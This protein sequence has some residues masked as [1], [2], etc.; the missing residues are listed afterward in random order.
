M[1]RLISLL[2][3]IAIITASCL[4]MTA[5]TEDPS[6]DDDTAESPAPDCGD[7]EIVTPSLK[8]YSDKR[9]VKLSQIVYQRPDI[10]A[11]IEAF[12]AISELIRSGEGDFEQIIAAVEELEDDYESILTMRSYTQ[13]MRSADIKSEYWQGEYAVI[14]ES[15]PEFASAIED[16][17]VAAAQSPDA[18]RYEDEYFGEG[19]IEKYAGGGTLTDTLV[20]L[21]ERE[22]ELENRSSSL[23]GAN[24]VISYKSMTDTYDNVIAFYE[25]HYGKDSASCKS[26]VA[27]CTALYERECSRINRECFVELVKVRRDIADE[28]GFNTYVPVAYDDMSHD[29]TEEQML[30]YLNDISESVI[31]V[32][33]VLSTYIFNTYFDKH[34]APSLDR[35]SLIN[36]LYYVLSDMDEELADIYSYMLAFEL[37][38]VEMS[39]DERSGGSFTTYL[40]GYDAPLL[41]VST[42]GRV[43]DYFTLSHEFGH[44]A[45]YF[46]NGSS[47]ASVDI[48]EVSSTSLELLS[49][50]AL[51]GKL[52][53]AEYKYLQYAEICSA[54]ETFVYQGFYALFEHYVYA[55]G[56]DDISERAIID[57]MKRAA[58]DMG[59]N[60]D[61]LVANESLGVY[62]PLDY[63]LIPHIIEYP[64]YVESYC[65]SL[66]VAL[67]IYY[68][69]VDFEGSG[70][71]AYK[72]LLD[73]SEGHSSFLE[74]LDGAGLTSPFA[75]G[76]LEEL[77]YK[78]YY[79]ILGDYRVN[80]NMKRKNSEA[81]AS[82]FFCCVHV[83]R[84]SSEE[85]DDLYQNPMNFVEKSPA[86]KRWAY[87][88]RQARKRTIYTEIP[89]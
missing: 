58:R 36:G 82:L 49:L 66:S 42:E 78:L 43:S 54:L 55:I 79:D 86:D 47:T 52:S 24:V 8:D 1:S 70:V 88:V 64:F 10:P 9:T 63:V 6:S 48:S 51:E 23:S 53:A 16:L 60:P 62:S 5:C 74:E 27:A 65:T 41:F 29:Y 56:E 83:L 7:K 89:V 85:A 61:A 37:Y 11:A 39:S 57:A 50:L 32:Y 34:S 18:E 21:Y 38:D 3:L 72:V 17:F 59:L 67:E 13:F 12:S 35:C 30:G 69:E 4:A 81:S 45:D 2:L 71:G 84:T 77:A 22:R 80:E 26:A 76:A 68:K 31:P 46:I 75:D 20:A 14:S 33:A 15:Y 73:R 87:S 19:L 25:E 40:N 28:L 44:F